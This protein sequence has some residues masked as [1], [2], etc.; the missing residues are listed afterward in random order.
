MRCERLSKCLIVFAFVAAACGREQPAPP[1]PPPITETHAAPQPQ[2]TATHVDA[3]PAMTASYDKAMD[4]LR[5]VLRFRF[6][7]DEAG[8][9]AE[10]TM[11]RPTV[12]AEKIEFRANGDEWRAEAGPQ[13]ISWQKRKGNAWIAT[14]APEF[15]NHLY[16]RA[17]LVFDPMKKEGA[18]QLVPGE[19]GA[20]T[21]LFRFTDA[22]TGNVHEVWVSNAGNHVERI[23]IA[24]VMDM[25]I[26]P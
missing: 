25:T 6:V 9:H 12:G 10:G 18:A 22:N 2:I 8:V 20:A 17:T 14:K 21:T 23:R 5:S 13:G 7:I 11:T 1:P 3:T 19:A 4:W 16:Q 24:G 15:G 26:Q